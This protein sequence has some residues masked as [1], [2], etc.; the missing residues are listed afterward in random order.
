MTVLTEKEHIVPKP[1]VE[2]NIKMKKSKNPA[3]KKVKKYVYE[4]IPYIA[5]ILLI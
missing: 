2:D 5:Q 4:D 3:K 1:E